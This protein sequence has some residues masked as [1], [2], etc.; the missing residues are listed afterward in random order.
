MPD[1]IVDVSQ[2]E[3]LWKLAIHCRDE[4]AK[5]PIHRIAPFAIGVVASTWFMA[6]IFREDLRKCFDKLIGSSIRVPASSLLMRSNYPQNLRE[7]FDPAPK[8]V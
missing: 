3:V 7:G 5:R 8:T 6:R 4:I 2:V 1:K